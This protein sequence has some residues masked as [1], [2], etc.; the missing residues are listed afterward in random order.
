MFHIND[1]LPLQ[2]FQHLNSFLKVQ[3]RFS[4]SGISGAFDQ[5]LLNEWNV[6]PMALQMGAY[7]LNPGILKATGSRL[8]TLHRLEAL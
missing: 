2:I 7:H 8:G 5:I 1:A 4:A 6:G 3:K